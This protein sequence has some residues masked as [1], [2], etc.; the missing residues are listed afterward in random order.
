[1]SRA[2]GRL[3]DRLWISRRQL[4]S[5]TGHL[6]SPLGCAPYSYNAIAIL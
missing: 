4:G 2:Y 6:L 5:A 3:V 1:M